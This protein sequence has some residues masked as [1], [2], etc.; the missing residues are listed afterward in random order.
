MPYNAGC[1][2]YC[3]WY[4]C[5]RT[6]ICSNNLRRVGGI[7]CHLFLHPRLRC[8][9]FASSELFARIIIIFLNE[10]SKPKGSKLIAQDDVS[11]NTAALLFQAWASSV[12]GELLDM[13]NLCSHPIHTASK[14]ALSQVP[15]WPICAWKFEKHWMG[16]ISYSSRH[17]QMSHHQIKHPSL[18]VLVCHRM[19][20]IQNK[21]CCFFS[22]AFLVRGW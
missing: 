3:R 22:P 8:S 1:Y 4:C 15:R 13:Q 12:S 9:R 7:T 14:Y 21:G 16:P 5:Y 6:L 11:T 20:T 17:F 19:W 2:H 18:T 10:L